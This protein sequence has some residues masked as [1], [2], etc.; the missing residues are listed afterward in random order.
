MSPLTVR[1]ARSAVLF[2]ALGLLLG[3]W[4]AFDRA[5][6]AMARP[7]HAEL[8]LWG[9][10]TLLIY[11]LAYHMLPRFAGRPLPRRRAADYQSY[12]AIGGVALAS[13]GWLAQLWAPP[14]ARPLL[15]LGGALQLG[16][17]L[18]FVAL[19]LPLLTKEKRHVH[20]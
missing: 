6:G 20:P 4:F 12:A 2:F 10:V 9:G 1:L 18:A 7:L 13:L 15:A 8:N 17:A 14:A 19:I 11:G 3:V 5:V 16:A